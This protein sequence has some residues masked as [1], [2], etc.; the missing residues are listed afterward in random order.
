MVDSSSI[1]SKLFRN[2]GLFFTSLSGLHLGV[3]GI[4]PVIDV[5]KLLDRR[6]LMSR[7]DQP[8]L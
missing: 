1:G 7:G 2:D 5:D 4:D 3:D 8:Y 6:F